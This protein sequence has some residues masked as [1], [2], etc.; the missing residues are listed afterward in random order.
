[1]KGERIREKGEEQQGHP[2][3]NNRERNQRS[4]K[5]K[6][7]MENSKK[8]KESKGMQKKCEE[9]H[10]ISSLQVLFKK[11]KRI[12]TEKTTKI[13]SNLNKRYFCRAFILI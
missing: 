13:Y 4:H 7:K 8:V 1:M 5:Q 12:L 9:N 10:K 6:N 2:R 3:D 11:T